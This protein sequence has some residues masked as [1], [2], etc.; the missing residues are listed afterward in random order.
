VSAL[1]AR[2]KGSHPA[3]R[4]VY[5]LRV[6]DGGG[7]GDCRILLAEKSRELGARYDASRFPAMCGA[8]R[9]TPG[10]DEEITSD[11]YGSTLSGYAPIRDG[12]GRTV[13]LLGIDIDATTIQE[14]WR[15]AFDILAGI[16]GL[17]AVVGAALGWFFARRIS[18]PVHEIALAMDRVEGGDLSV[19]VPALP[20][21]EVGR[22]GTQFNRMTE[23]LEER[24]RL[25]QSLLLAMEVQQKLLPAGPPSVEGVDVAGCSDYCDETGGDYFDYPRTWEV[26]GGRLAITLGDVTGH[27]IG[28]ALL[29]STARAVLRASCEGDCAP[30]AILG[31]VNRHLSRD[32]TNG[33]FMTLFYGVLDPKEGTLRYANAGQ[34]GCFV[35]RGED[36]RVEWLEAGGP[37][38]GV[39]DGLPYPESTVGGLQAG[40]V[41]VLASDGVYETF[42]PAG[43]PFGY[44]RL[45]AVAVAA[46][47][48]P[49]EEIVRAILA[50]AEAHR[51]EGPQTDDVTLVVAR[52]RG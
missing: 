2:V 26:P 39:V 41:V 20:D 1:A 42:D 18:R 36:G 23:G 8:F 7:P 27:G 46:R 48:R 16:G 37:P 34:G 17:A 32:A 9:G 40:D 51:A 30:D 4:E 6:P 11:E 25:K 28:A 43:Q 33:R 13:G 29:M 31:V 45:E 10:A 21:D 49:A 19:R 35:V 22:L 24:Q 12:K 5:A 52:L 3:F 50:A 38:L 44:E 14:M 47:A 15:D